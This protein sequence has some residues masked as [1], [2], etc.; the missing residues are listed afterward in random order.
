ML[1]F[2]FLILLASLT[3]SIKG[4]CYQSDHQISVTPN[5]VSLQVQPGTFKLDSSLIIYISDESLKREATYLNNLLFVTNWKGYPISL[6]SDKPDSSYII[7]KLDEKADF[8]NDEAYRLS[9]NKQGITISAIT[10]TGIFYGIQ[11]LRQLLP[12]Q[13]E[14]IDPSLIPKNTIWEIPAVEIY[15]YPRFG[16]RGM[17]L[18]VARHFFS[19]DFVKKYIDLLAMYKF[20]RFH[21]HLTE[22]QGWRIEIKKYPR[23]TEIGAWRDSTLIGNYGTGKYDGIRYGGY[24]TQEE[25]KEVVAYATERHITVIPEIEL[26]GH[27]SAALAS[28]PELGCFNKEVKVAT[29]WGIFEDIYCPKEET[30]EFLE[31][32]L[33]EV[34]V[35]FPSRYIHIGGDEAPKTQWEES[36]IAQA[37]IKREGLKDEHE[38]QSYFVGRIESYL[39]SKGRQIIGWDEIMEGGLAPQATIM[40]WSWQGKARAI[41]AAKTGH[42]VIMTPNATSYF[43]HFQAEPIDEEPIAIGGLT[44][45][46]DVYE[47]EPVPSELNEN[48][49]KF[50][51]GAQ[52]NVWTE[53]IHT[54][55][56]VEYMAFPR[57]I[58]LSEV[59]WNTSD[60]R[61]WEAFL[62][63]LQSQFQRLDILG[64]NYAT[65]AKMK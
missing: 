32:V 38:L 59:L 42:D 41:E 53:Y 12:T 49:A 19:V 5:P 26:P 61:N 1:R 34:I 50:I 48:E 55:A 31:D 52:A 57:A 33:D 65:H 7:L 60:S 30:F 39:N 64:V 28:Y 40:S 21:W 22:D 58:A 9:V 13:I 46:K 20:N 24:Y 6:L 47:F 27:S 17:H 11:T 62:E 18:D 16:Y 37:V 56:K 14:H 2:L 25:I 54:G 23:L 10:K 3:F 45:L 44:T 36:D 63:S 29:T 8:K 4:I 51:I 35:L 15:D 43:D